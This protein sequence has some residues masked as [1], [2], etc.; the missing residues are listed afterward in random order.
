MHHFLEQI[1]ANSGI[2]RP[3]NILIAIIGGERDDFSLGKFLPDV[4]HCFD[5][6]AVRKP[7]IHQRD[8]GLVPAKEKHG[9]G[10]SAGLGNQ[11][12]TGGVGQDGRNALPDEVMIINR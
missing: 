6:G 1:T 4:D 8:I 5:S 7:Q 11:L 2:Q 12:D 3:V 9:G 10:G